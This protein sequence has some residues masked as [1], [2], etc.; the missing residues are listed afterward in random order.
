M[1]SGVAIATDGG[2]VFVADFERVAG[3]DAVAAGRA[4]WARF[5]PAS[6]SAQPGIQTLPRALWVEVAEV[7]T[8][9]DSRL[10]RTTTN[11]GG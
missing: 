10:Q 4:A 7:V 2:P 5:C 9:L 8:V 11:G 6:F 1:L 3:R